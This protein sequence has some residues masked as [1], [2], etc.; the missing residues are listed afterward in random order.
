MTMNGYKRT[1]RELKPET[2]KKISASL[3]GRSKSPTHCKNISKGLRGYWADV[4]SGE[5]QDF[6]NTGRVV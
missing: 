4:P 2:K 1:Q 5:S 6:T 3:K